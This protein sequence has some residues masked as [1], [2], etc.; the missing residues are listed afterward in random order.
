MSKKNVALFIEALAKQ[1]DLNVKVSKA[2]PTIAAWTQVAN[3]GGFQFRDEDLFQVMQKLLDQK[4]PAEQMIPA[5][6]AAQSELDASQLDRV[7]GGAARTEA[8]PVTVSPST[9]QRVSALGG[10]GAGAA[11]WG[12]HIKGPFGSMPGG[13]TVVNQG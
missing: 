9:V 8:P 12:G 1:K 3:Q 13:S 4:V 10:V 5:F 2:Q 11:E 6:I 7:A